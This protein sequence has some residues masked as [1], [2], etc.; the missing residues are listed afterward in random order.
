MEEI[1]SPLLHGLKNFRMVIGNHGYPNGVKV[2]QDGSY[3]DM[4]DPRQ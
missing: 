1:S 3:A 4:V 2:V